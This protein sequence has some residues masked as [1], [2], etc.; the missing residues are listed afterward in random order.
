[1]TNLRPFVIKYVGLHVAILYTGWFVGWRVSDFSVLKI[2]CLVACLSAT[3]SLFSGGVVLP[4][5]CILSFIPSE[6]NL[7]ASFTTAAF[8]A[9]MHRSH[10]GCDLMNC[11]ARIGSLYPILLLC[12]VIESAFLWQEGWFLNSQ[13]SFYFYNL[14]CPWLLLTT[15]NTS[16]SFCS[17]SLC[18]FF[19][20][21]LFQLLV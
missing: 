17:L 14:L 21:W 13:T 15:D 11:A 7:V 2:A 5:C 12:R 16:P 3:V 9:F 4:S 8:R 18:Q 20:P 6:N 1:M 10:R 19:F